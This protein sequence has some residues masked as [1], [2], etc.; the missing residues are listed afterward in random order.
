MASRGVIIRS[1]VILSVVLSLMHWAAPVRAQEASPESPAVLDISTQTS[2]DFPRGIT[3]KVDLGALPRVERSRIELHYAIGGNETEHLVFVPDGARSGEH[4]GVIELPVDLR[5]EFVPSGVTLEY[6]WEVFSESGEIGRTRPETV[7]WF[8]TRWTWETM[9]AN[10]VILHSY[11]LSPVFARSI[12]DSAQSTVA[13]LETRYALERSM[14]VDIWIYPSLD[15]YRGAQQPNSRESIAGASYPGFFL[16]VAVIPDGDTREVGRVIPHE[17]SHQVLY[18]AT[19]NPFT[20]PPF[21]FD[22]GLATHYQIGGTDGYLQMVI[23]AHQQ[24]RLFDLGSLDTTFPYLPAQATLAYAASWSAVEFIGQ[25]F[26]DEGIQRL[27]A[28]FAAGESFDTAIEDALGMPM[29]ELNGLWQ[30]WIGQQAVQTPGVNSANAGHFPA[31]AW[32]TRSL[33]TG[34]GSAI[35][36]EQNVSCTGRNVT[37]WFAPRSTVR[38]WAPWMSRGGYALQSSGRAWT[39][40]S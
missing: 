30:V 26:G 22:E 35:A 3:F 31:A 18:Q 40:K 17:V 11:D 6:H 20:V 21:W 38:N 16:I 8:D 15:D 19:R 34:N 39:R 23:A 37:S 1:M 33:G 24:D 2:I 5:S 7:T 36:M 29:T 12:L 32:H 25:R 14:P 27:I 4:G 10:Q 9:R 13:D 28:A